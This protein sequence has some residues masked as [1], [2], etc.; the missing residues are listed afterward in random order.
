M[1]VLG[2]YEAND[3]IVLN[4]NFVTIDGKLYILKYALVGHSLDSSKS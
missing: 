3:Y 1:V 2:H 4:F